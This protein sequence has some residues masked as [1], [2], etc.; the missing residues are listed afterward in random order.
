MQQS[1]D[2]L[3]LLQVLAA[4]K[5]TY[6]QFVM[7]GSGLSSCHFVPRSIPADICSW[8]CLW[9]VP[10][11]LGMAPSGSGVAVIAKDRKIIVE[12]CWQ[13]WLFVLVFDACAEGPLLGGSI[14]EQCIYLVLLNRTLQ[15]TPVDIQ[16]GCELSKKCPS[17]QEFPWV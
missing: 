8:S 6:P 10:F 12:I 17:R 14:Y 9:P 11:L 1:W 15:G 16:S 3:G 4:Q 7:A 13:Q 2:V 5:K